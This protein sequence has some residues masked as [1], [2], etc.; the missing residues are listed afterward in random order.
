MARQPLVAITLIGWRRLGRPSV[1]VIVAGPLNDCRS[2]LDCTPTGRRLV[3]LKRLLALLAPLRC[4]PRRIAGSSAG[5]LALLC[6]CAAPPSPPA[7]PALQ[8]AATQVVGTAQSASTSIAPTVSVGQTQVSAT[9]GAAQ[10]QVIP[11]VVAVQTQVTGDCFGCFDSGADVG[12]GRQGAAGSDRSD[13]KCNTGPRGDR[14]HTCASDCRHRDGTHGPSSRD[15]SRPHGA[16]RGD[17]GC[18]C[19]LGCAVANADL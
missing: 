10:T 4:R 15:A 3:M 14:G 5:V 13:R 18:G 17:R 12:C 1:I 9:V 11:T 6:A 16:S 7:T 2:W 8:A 19:H